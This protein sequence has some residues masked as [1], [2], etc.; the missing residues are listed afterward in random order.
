MPNLQQAMAIGVDEEFYDHLV[1]G[2][3][4]E[5]WHFTHIQMALEAIFVK[6]FCKEA[7]DKHDR[8]PL[9]EIKKELDEEFQCFQKA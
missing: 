2:T 1:S 3:S 8:I 9:N 6:R 7:P 4:A 5:G